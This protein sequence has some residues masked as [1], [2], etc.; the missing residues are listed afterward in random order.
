MIDNV[1]AFANTRKYG[2]RISAKDVIIGHRAEIQLALG[3]MRCRVPVKNWENRTT[4]RKYH[5]VYGNI[6][7]IDD[8]FTWTLEET[9]SQSIQFSDFRNAVGSNLGRRIGPTQRISPSASSLLDHGA[10][11]PRLLHQVAGARHF[12]KC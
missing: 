10:I 9:P 2:I 8:F 5:A 7:P 4:D 11:A 12:C 3:D 6:M 1:L